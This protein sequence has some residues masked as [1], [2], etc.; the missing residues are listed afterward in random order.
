MTKA[1]I[2]QALG[3]R[4]VEVCKRVGR[5]DPERF[6]EAREF[7]S[8]V[9]ASFRNELPAKLKSRFPSLAI[10]DHWTEAESDSLTAIRLVSLGAEKA[11]APAPAPP[12]APFLE[13]LKAT[14]GGVPLF[15]LLTERYAN[16]LNFLFAPEDEVREHLLMS[17]MVSD[18]RRIEGG[19]IAP[20]DADDVLLKLN[21]V[22]LGAAATN[23]LRFLDALNYYYE[24]LPPAWHPDAENRW[25]LPSWLALYARALIS[26]S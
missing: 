17:L 9:R 23:D 12:T 10:H 11:M 7:V 2:S 20:S 18:R 19:T 13:K 21:F 26:W 1:L 4:L 25:L 16:P 8:A 5:L 24:L 14:P 6:G 15:Q 22:S 3:R